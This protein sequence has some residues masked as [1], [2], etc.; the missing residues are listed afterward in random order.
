MLLLGRVQAQSLVRVLKSPK[1]YHT[2]KKNKFLILGLYVIF[3]VL[4]TLFNILSIFYDEH[5]NL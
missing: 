1:L 5:L 4:F 2:T 3:M